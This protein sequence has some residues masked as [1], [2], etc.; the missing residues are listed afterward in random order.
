[1]KLT[2]EIRRQLLDFS[3]LLPTVRIK[4]AK[5]SLIH[6]DMF[7]HDCDVLPLEPKEPKI[8]RCQVQHVNETMLTPKG[9]DYHFDQLK[10]AFIRG[11]AKAVDEYSM[12]I[13]KIAGIK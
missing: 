2:A 7:Y 5:M 12:K 8:F 9:S 1:M 4:E 11:G 10:K 3:K 13:R 6:T